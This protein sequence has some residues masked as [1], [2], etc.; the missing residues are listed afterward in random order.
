M[1]SWTA[2]T[3]RLPEDK[4]IIVCCRMRYKGE[5]WEYFTDIAWTSPVRA[6]EPKNKG[7]EHGSHNHVLWIDEIHGY[8]IIT[9]HDMWEGQQEFEFIGW[10]EIPDAEELKAEPLK[11][12]TLE[13]WENLW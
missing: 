2:F 7:W 10:M 12:I 5:K 8:Q 11:S 6:Y 13:Q 4:E 1:N 9:V 3:E